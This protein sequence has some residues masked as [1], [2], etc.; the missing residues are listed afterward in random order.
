MKKHGY[1]FWKGK[2][3]EATETKNITEKFCADHIKKLKAKNTMVSFGEGKPDIL[4]CKKNK[5]FEFYEV[6]PY[7]E[8]WGKKGHTDWH[9]ASPERRKLSKPQLKK[10]RVM[11]K[12]GLKLYVIYYDR[13]IPKKGKPKLTIHKQKGKPNPR[14]VTSA[15]LKN[16]D[17]T[18]PAEY[19]EWWN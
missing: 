1:P 18:D 17:A 2:G 12:N 4:V 8:Q 9:P 14:E 7:L 15:M 19:F 5:S 11:I 10:F 13:I 3:D 6:K 16:L